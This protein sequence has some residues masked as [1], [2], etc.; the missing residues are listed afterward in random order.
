MSVKKC[1]NCN[2]WVPTCIVRGN[3]CEWCLSKNDERGRE[4][5][6]DKTTKDIGIGKQGH[7]LWSAFRWILCNIF[8]K[9]EYI[10]GGFTDI[11]N[12]R[13]WYC[14]F[15]KRISRIGLPPIKLKLKPPQMKTPM[16]KK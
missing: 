16:M 13:Y 8:N 10:H 12:Q 15:C 5:G 4:K 14:S 9:H 2:R 3:E 7:C 1:H 11:Y 6:I